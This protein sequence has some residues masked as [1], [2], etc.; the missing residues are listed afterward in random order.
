M[1]TERKG[2]EKT[3]RVT[4]ENTWG[5][6]FITPWELLGSGCPFELSLWEKTRDPRKKMKKNQQPVATGWRPG[7]RPGLKYLDFHSGNKA[8]SWK[9]NR[10][11]ETMSVNYSSGRGLMSEH[12]SNWQN[13]VTPS[14]ERS[15]VG[16]GELVPR[17]RCICRSRRAPGSVPS[18]TW[19]ITTACSSSFQ[20]LLLVSLGTHRHVMY[21]EASV[22]TQ[23]YIK[24]KIWK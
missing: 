10:E 6:I 18:T 7:N 22:Y 3:P 8:A 20:Q 14:F 12:I 2:R 9:K 17:L 4:S 13:S 16:G 24:I 23:T 5:E 15:A 11:W 1:A 19:Q 21:T